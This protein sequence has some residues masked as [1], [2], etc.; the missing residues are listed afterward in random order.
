MSKPAIHPPAEQLRDYS[1]GRLGDS[2]SRHIERHLMG[3]LECKEQ[4]FEVPASDDFIDWLQKVHRERHTTDG[5]PSP[6]DEPAT[7]GD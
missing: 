1:L 6:Q 2:D 5:M 3:C 7:P 4:L